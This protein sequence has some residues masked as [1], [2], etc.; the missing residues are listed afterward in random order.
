MK[1]ARAAAGTD[2]FLSGT[3]APAYPNAPTVPA[4][5]NDAAGHHCHLIVQQPSTAERVAAWRDFLDG[6]DDGKVLIDLVHFDYRRAT[7]HEQNSVPCLHDNE[8]FL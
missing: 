4:N 3:P 7:C 1:Q 6:F 5:P 8:P 2:P